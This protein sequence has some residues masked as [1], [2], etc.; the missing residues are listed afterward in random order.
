M[1]PTD[2]GQALLWRRFPPPIYR[3]TAP[4]TACY[5]QSLVILCTLSFASAG[6]C[7]YWMFSV[8][9][10]ADTIIRTINKKCCKHQCFQWVAVVFGKVR[11]G[12]AMND[13]IARQ[14]INKKGF[15]CSRER[16]RDGSLPLR[17]VHAAFRLLLSTSET[18]SQQSKCS[19]GSGVGD[20]RVQ[21]DAQR[22]HDLQDRAKARIALA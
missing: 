6:G 14:G 4:G 13:G 11:E 1:G 16:A 3:R 2:A 20:F 9:P 19:R 8:S 15:R 10:L 22:V 21:L 5:C 18:T 7:F 17:R 12:A